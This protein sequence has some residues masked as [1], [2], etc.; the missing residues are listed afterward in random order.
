MYC[1]YRIYCLSR[2]SDDPA[3]K[4]LVTMGLCSYFGA[5]ICWGLD[6]GFCDLFYVEWGLPNLQVLT[7]SIS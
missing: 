1:L 3:L 7:T 4:R 5:L 6:I 2:D